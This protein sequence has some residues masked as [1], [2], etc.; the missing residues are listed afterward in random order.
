MMNELSLC[1]TNMRHI[2]VKII[3]YLICYMY[4]SLF[5]YN[6]QTFYNTSTL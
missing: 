2:T 1:R 5:N 6:K 3:L 4:M